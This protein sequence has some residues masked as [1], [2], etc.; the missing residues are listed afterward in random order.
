M[1]VGTFRSERPEAQYGRKLRM[2]GMGGITDDLFSHFKQKS[3][4]K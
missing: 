2:A 1:S 4:T 3:H